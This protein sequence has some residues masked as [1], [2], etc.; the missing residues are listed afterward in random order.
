MEE[1]VV[2]VAVLAQV[3]AHHIPRVLSVLELAVKVML[4]D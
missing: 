3:V 2:L 1:Q 4:A